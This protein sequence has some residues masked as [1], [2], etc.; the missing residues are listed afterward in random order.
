[1]TG[2]D[3]GAP[4][5]LGGALDEAARLLETGDA[6]AAERAMHRAA[7]CC[8]VRPAST[9]SADELARVRALLL[10]CLTA[11]AQLRTRV[12]AEMGR[13]GTSSR[14]RSAYER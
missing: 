13:M 10:R 5:T 7:A 1:M 14:A 2:I 6:E 11:E 3:M 9:L 8:T 12:V 4:A